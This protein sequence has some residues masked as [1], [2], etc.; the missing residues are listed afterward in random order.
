MHSGDIHFLLYLDITYYSDPA[1][2]SAFY[3]S[4]IQCP[5]SNLKFLI[6]SYT[7]L[8]VNFFCKLMTTKYSH[9]ITLELITAL[10]IMQAIKLHD[11]CAPLYKLLNCSKMDSR[12]CWSDSQQ[13][14]VFRNTSNFASCTI[15]S[16]R[17][18]HHYVQAIKTCQL[19]GVVAIS[20]TSHH[21]LP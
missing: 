7:Y 11:T 9:N 19:R 6:F 16:N 4:T 5:Y 13:R 17:I 8:F 20:I 3:C 12:K 10:H 1:C 14:N 15:A 18:Q 21:P 2:F